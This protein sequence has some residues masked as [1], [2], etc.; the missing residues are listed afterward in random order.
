MGM[1]GAQAAGQRH[2]IIPQ[3]MGGDE[4]VRVYLPGSRHQKRMLI[5]ARHISDFRK[6]HDACIEAVESGRGLSQSQKSWVARWEKRKI[7]DSERKELL[8]E[9]LRYLRE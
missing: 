8:D 1:A 5:P 2:F 7:L 9:V 3:G 4:F 6:R